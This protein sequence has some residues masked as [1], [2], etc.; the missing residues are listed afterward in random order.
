MCGEHPLLEYL[1]DPL[2]DG[3][4]TGY[5]KAIKRFR[6]ALPKV[7]IGVRSWFKSSLE[8]I[9][10][11][12]QIVSKDGGDDDE[13]GESRPDTQGSNPGSP[14][15]GDNKSSQ[16]LL[17]LNKLKFTPGVIHIERSLL[18][19]ASAYKLWELVQYQ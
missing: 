15:E 12:T 8:T 2:V 4:S 11:Y 16:A 10:Q 1:E 17:E 14:R 5:Q 6:E 13:E 18:P 3:D 7:K 9:K 19:K